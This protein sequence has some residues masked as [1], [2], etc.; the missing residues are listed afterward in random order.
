MK[1][2]FLFGVLILLGFVSVYPDTTTWGALKKIHFYH[3]AGNQEMVLENLEA[4]DFSGV[5]QQTKHKIAKNLIEFGDTFLTSKNY[6]LATAFYEKVLNLSPHYWYLYNKLERIK[7]LKGSSLLG[8]KNTVKQFF[9]LFKNFQPS[10]MMVNNML[11][12]LFYVTMLI[13]F[14]FTLFFL[15]KYFRLSGNDLLVSDNWSQS[16]KKIVILMVLLL[17]PMILL[18]GWIFYPFLIIGF[19]WV[20]LNETEKQSITFVLILVGVASILYS[21]NL[22]LEER[23]KSEEF[24]TL[25]D[26]YHGKLLERDRYENFDDELKIIQAHAYYTQEKK[27]VA[28]EILNSTDERYKSELKYIL[29]GNIY[30]K[31]DKLQESINNFKECL[32]INEKNQIAL[33]NFTLALLKNNNTD[34]FNSYAKWIPQISQYKTKV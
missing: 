24:K 11:N 26:V 18:A 25:Q 29:L 21:F 14:I 13:L 15:T 31:S 1:Q 8:V 9:M 32:Q 4:I 16:I 6:A 34:V 30:F 10:F 5:D 19:L 22:L 17:W 20:Y 28:L 27:D 33:N 3:N 2:R 12:V 7:H 23:A